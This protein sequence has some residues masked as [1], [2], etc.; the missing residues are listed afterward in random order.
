MTIGEYHEQ[1][2]RTRALP[3][4]CGN[5]NRMPRC[6]MEDNTLDFGATDKPCWEPRP[7]P[8]YIRDLELKGTE[9]EL[10]KN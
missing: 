9:D 10:N 7:V 3:H 2:Q 6:W 8:H 1:Q 5:C 4:E